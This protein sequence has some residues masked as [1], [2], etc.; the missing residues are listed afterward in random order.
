MQDWILAD[1]S[2]PAFPALHFQ[3]PRLTDAQD[4][5]SHESLRPSSD[6]VSC[7]VGK[8][9]MNSC[10]LVPHTASTRNH[11]NNLGRAESSP[12][13]Q[14]IPLVTMRCTIFTSNCP[15]FFDDH[16]PHLTHIRR[17]TRLTT[18]NGI[19][20]QLAVLQQYTSRSDR[21]GDR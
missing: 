9:T 15:F 12:F 7:L 17:P 19:R 3:R 4:M 14:R 13:T 8:L 16:H 10:L 11:K 2:S 18:P 20:I 1:H 21:Q 6:C 5:E